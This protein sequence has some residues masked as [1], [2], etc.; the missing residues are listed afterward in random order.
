MKKYLLLL[1]FGLIFCHPRDIYPISEQS[2]GPARVL[3]FVGLAITAVFVYKKIRQNKEVLK[4]AE[5]S[6]KDEKQEVKILPEKIENTK[7]VEFTPEKPNNEENKLE[8]AQPN[9]PVKEESV[10]LRFLRRFKKYF[11]I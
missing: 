10:L 6:K 1:C 5:N 9:V 3:L 11:H 2:S 8:I 4:P 7:P